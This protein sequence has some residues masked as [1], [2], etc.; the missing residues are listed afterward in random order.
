[1]TKLALLLGEGALARAAFQAAQRQFG[2]NQVFGL[3]LS[4]AAW[5]ELPL[6]DLDDLPTAILNVKAL[7]PTHICVAGRADLSPSR[8]Q[9]MANSIG[10]D[11]TDATTDIGIERIFGLV[12]Q[13]IDA[14][15]IGLHHFAQDLLAGEGHLF[16][17]DQTVDGGAISH[18]LD[19]ARKFGETDLGQ[20]VVFAGQQPI[21]GED[22][23]GTDALLDRVTIL[24]QSNDIPDGL[25]LVK[26]KKPQ[27]SG[28]GDLPT[29]GIN[30]IERAA[31][32][33]ISV[34]LVE[35]GQTLLM[36]QE[37]LGEVCAQHGVTILGG[38]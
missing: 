17:P 23:G 10:L 14:Q 19:V 20:A 27:Q 38:L 7:A 26:A 1:M 25:W 12:A 5:P 15:P 3:A 36:D 8:R 32:A 34:I 21:A 11:A 33:G 22:I 18:L 9:S 29:I 4:P 2:V 30:T 31:G 37:Q 35:A 13:K 24:R 28:V 16:G 6:F